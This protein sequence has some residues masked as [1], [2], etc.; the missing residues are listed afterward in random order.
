VKSPKSDEVRRQEFLDKIEQEGRSSPSGLQWANFTKLLY[1]SR[2]G[3]SDRP[4]VP[5]ILA[6]SAESNQSKHER[7]SEQLSWAIRRGCLD[8]ALAFLEKLPEENWNK[9]SHEDWNKD[10]F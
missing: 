7:L 6:A 5:L 4:P 3:E 8:A 10:W 1:E 2:S 9:G